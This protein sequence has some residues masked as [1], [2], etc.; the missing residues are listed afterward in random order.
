MYAL[1]LEG[2]D[3]TQIVSGTVDS[4][5]KRGA[6]GL[7]PK[8]LSAY[9]TLAEAALSQGALLTVAREA[10][11][12]A[13]LQDS[14]ADKDTK[15]LVDERLIGGYRLEREGTLVDASFK[16]HLLRAYRNATRA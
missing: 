9:R 14:G 4:L 3:A 11:K 6:L 13:A 10:D 16:A 2:K 1:S 15:V 12:Q 5:K 8:V 7:L